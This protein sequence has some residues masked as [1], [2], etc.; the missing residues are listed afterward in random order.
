MST[1]E[2]NQKL[3]QTW[4]KPSYFVPIKK[5]SNDNSATLEKLLSIAGVSVNNTEERI[6][7]Y[8]EATAHLIGYVGE[9]SAED[10]EKLKGKGYTASDVIGKRGLEEVLEARLKGK[11]GGKIFIKTEDGEEKVIAEKPAEEGKQLH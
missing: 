1:D 6:Y 11:P 10:L 3:K 8:K 4:V 9:A 2:V 7:P 5:M